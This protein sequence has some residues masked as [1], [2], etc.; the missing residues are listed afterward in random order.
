MGLD[1]FGNPSGWLLCLLWLSLFYVVF[2]ILVGLLARSKQAR[3]LILARLHGVPITLVD[4]VTISLKGVD[5]LVVVKA[6][7]TAGQAGI[8]VPVAELRAHCLAGGDVETVA[9]G[10]LAARHAGV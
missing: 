3:A 7:V 8:A 9:A 6:C 5:P 1:F 2:R 10:L 4:V